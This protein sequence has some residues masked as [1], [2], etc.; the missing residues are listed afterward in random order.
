MILMHKGYA[1]KE[2]TLGSEQSVITSLIGNTHMCLCGECK[3]LE[4]ELKVFV[5]WT[6]TNFLSLL[7]E[8]K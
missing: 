4:T 8:R 1:E 3:P 5:V 2:Q 7:I 6:Q